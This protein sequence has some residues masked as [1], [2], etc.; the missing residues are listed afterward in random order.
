MYRNPSRASIALNIWTCH[1]AWILESYQKIWVA[2]RN[3]GIW[4]YHIAHMFA[5]TITVAPTQKFCL[6]SLNIEC[7]NLSSTQPR[8]MTIKNLPEALNRFTNLKY[9]NLSGLRKHWLHRR[10]G[11]IAFGNLKE[12]VYLDLSR[13]SGVHGVL[14]TLG[15][16]TK[17]QYL[18]LSGCSCF[19]ACTELYP[20]RMSE[21]IGNLTELRYL[22]LSHCSGTQEHPKQ[23]FFVF[24]LV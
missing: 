16:L 15:S 22:N 23:A 8:P 2:F 20:S 24:G 6:L 1:T 7:L 17:L 12:L 18:N 13:C 14:D 21:A 9:L 3:C 5:V 19:D 11:P 10:E 4:T